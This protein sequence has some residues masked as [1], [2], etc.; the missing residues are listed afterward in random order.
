MPLCGK[1]IL[2][3]LQNMYF[4]TYRRFFSDMVKKCNLKTEEE[5]AHH[6]TQSFS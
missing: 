1:A 3:Q 2:Q 5:K 6:Y 4:R